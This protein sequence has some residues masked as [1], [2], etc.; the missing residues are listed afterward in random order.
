VVYFELL[1]VWPD[2]R[3]PHVVE[4]SAPIDRRDVANGIPY[5][6]QQDCSSTA[7]ESERSGFLTTEEVAKYLAVLCL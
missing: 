6:G 3:K 4:C 5:A 1:S 7:V 2:G